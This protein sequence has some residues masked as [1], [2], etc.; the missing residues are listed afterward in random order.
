[1]VLCGCGV[2]WS[3]ESVESVERGVLMAGEV[4]GEKCVLAITLVKHRLIHIAANPD[5]LSLSSA[6]PLKW[7]RL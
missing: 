2:R 6:L 1:M 3:V 4:A 7:S 5:Y